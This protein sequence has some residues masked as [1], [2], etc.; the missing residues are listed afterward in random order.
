MS[1]IMEYWPL[2]LA[3]IISCALT[4]LMLK[5]VKRNRE[6]PKPI[7]VVL[8]KSDDQEISKAVKETL[9]KPRFL[10]IEVSLP[11]GLHND[12]PSPV[13]HFCGKGVAFGQDGIIAFAKRLEKYSSK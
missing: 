1:W 8:Y 4:G 10:M 3:L 12:G 5:S 2:G 6:E 7:A 9:K 13:A 11:G